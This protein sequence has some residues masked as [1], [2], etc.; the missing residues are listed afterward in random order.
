VNQQWITLFIHRMSRDTKCKQT[1]LPQ[2]TIVKNETSL[3]ETVKFDSSLLS[4]TEGSFRSRLLFGV[5]IYHRRGGVFAG[6]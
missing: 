3:G 2:C 6:F 1:L 5:Q 4:V